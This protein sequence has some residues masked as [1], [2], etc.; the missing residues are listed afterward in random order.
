M[1]FKI[2]DVSEFDCDF[3][4]IG[5]RVSIMSLWYFVQFDPCSMLLNVPGIIL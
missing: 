1:L 5:K 2:A 4:P 3:K